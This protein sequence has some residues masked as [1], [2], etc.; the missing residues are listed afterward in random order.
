[1]TQVDQN[2]VIEV[3]WGARREPAKRMGMC[4]LLW[5]HKRHRSSLGQLPERYAPRGTFL[6]WASAAHDRVQEEEF[7]GVVGKQYVSSAHSGTIKGTPGYKNKLI[8][9]DCQWLV[10]TNGSIFNFI[11]KSG[12]KLLPGQFWLCLTFASLSVDSGIALSPDF[13]SCGPKIRRVYCCD[14]KLFG[15]GVER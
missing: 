6:G 11:G 4:A 1:M 3:I 9:I 8:L 7:A 13:W 15:V 5:P 2:T 10:K 14:M 12:N